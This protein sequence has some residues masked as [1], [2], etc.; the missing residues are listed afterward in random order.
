MI[1]DSWFGSVTTAYEHA[2][3]K[4]HFT[5]A[6]KT[7]HSG[8]PKLYM[9]LEKMLVPMPSGVCCILETEVNGV[10]LQAIRYKY[11]WEKV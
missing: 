7:A 3:R 2:R 1:A 6:V 10:Q 9:Y 5:T 8:F 11:N 4:V